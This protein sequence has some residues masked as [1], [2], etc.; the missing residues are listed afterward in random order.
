LSR[1]DEEIEEDDIYSNDFASRS[2]QSATVS[3]KKNKLASSAKNADFEESG[4]S[5][6]FDE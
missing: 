6:A 5:D 1:D 3:S 2:I 4:Y